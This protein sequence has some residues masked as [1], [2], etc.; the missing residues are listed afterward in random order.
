[1]EE[2][3][4]DLDDFEGK[5]LYDYHMI[6]HSIDKKQ[7]DYLI[8]HFQDYSWEM[9]LAIA[10]C[11]VSAMPKV[12][13]L[14]SFSKNEADIE[15][16]F[17]SSKPFKDKDWTEWTEEDLE[18]ILDTRLIGEEQFFS[19]MYFSEIGL[20]DKKILFIDQNQKQ[21]QVELSKDSSIDRI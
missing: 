2:I 19:N 5:A 1:M 10:H 20:D 8:A 13:L 16:Q 21:Y 9:G 7:R 14:K 12:G 11:T 4:S 6:F 3:I 17:K 15:F 18:E